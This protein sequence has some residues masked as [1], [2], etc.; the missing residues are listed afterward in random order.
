MGGKGDP[1][2]IHPGSA[3]LAQNSPQQVL[4]VLLAF[5]APLGPEALGGQRLFV[6]L[7]L[8]PSELPDGGSDPPALGQVQGGLQ[9]PDRTTGSGEGG[10][11][12]RLSKAPPAFLLGHPKGHRGGL[13]MGA[14]CRTKQGP[15]VPPGHPLARIYDSEVAG[16]RGP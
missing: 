4:L 9:L 11:L 12:G 13:T 1:P 10:S 15:S 5:G 14:V 3:R 16:T 6:L 2:G 7:Q 8:L